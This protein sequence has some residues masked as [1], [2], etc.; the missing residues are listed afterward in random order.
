MESH[1]SPRP[2]HVFLVLLLTF[3]VYAPSMGNGFAMDDEPLAKSVVVKGGEP[4]PLI[5]H[6]QRP[7]FYFHQY[8]WWPERGNDEL[9]RPVTV[10]SY[11]LTYN[12]IT[13]PFLPADW[14]AYPH[15]V[16]NVLLHVWATWLVLQLVLWL[17]AG[18]LAA[19]LTALLF[20]LHAIHS[21]VVA[22]IIGRAELFSFCFGAQAVLL[23][24]RGGWWRYLLAAMLFFLAYC[25]KESSLT[26]IP[27]VPC[28]LLARG[29]LHD[30]EQRIW[31]IWQP[32]LLAVLLVT[33]VPFLVFMGLRHYVI[34]VEHAESLVGAAFSSNPLYLTDF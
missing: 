23:L 4:D 10:Y 7:Q 11:A 14:E 32:H 17:G 29:W 16:I 5:S 2:L 25:S 33:L 27:F 6:L 8:Y 21:E 20:G 31:D 24:L 1:Q 15:H 22:S 3:V 26:W 9:Y 30:R 28:T 18:G 34:Y 19:L 13:K 12:L